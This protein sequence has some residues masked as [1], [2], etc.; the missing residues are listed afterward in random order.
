MAVFQ[1]IND[2]TVVFCCVCVLRAWFQETTFWS[3]RTKWSMTLE[4][5]ER[6]WKYNTRMRFG[7]CSVLISV[8]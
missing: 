1:V 5:L 3:R 7:I 8:Q 6:S 2:N 4:P